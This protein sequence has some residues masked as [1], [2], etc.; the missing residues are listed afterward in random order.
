MTLREQLDIALAER[1]DAMR[2][3]GK[4]L[5][6]AQ[7]AEAE[8]D[9]WIETA[10]LYATNTDYWCDL[11][12]SCAADR[13]ILHKSLD[14]VARVLFCERDFKNGYSHSLNIA[15]EALKKLSSKTP[16]YGGDQCYIDWEWVAHHMEVIAD[17]A[18]KEIS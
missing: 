1:N 17:E 16:K 6:R 10:R 14:D 3:A 7:K 8:K 11:Y 13:N 5:V 4:M 12:R 2:W 15:F 18:L 9:A